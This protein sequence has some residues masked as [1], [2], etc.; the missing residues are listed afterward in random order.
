MPGTPADYDAV[1][2]RLL[3]LRTTATDKLRFPGIKL[4]LDGSIQG[5]TAV[6]KEPYYLKEGNGIW[7]IAP[8][9]IPR[10]VAAFHK[11][12]INVHAHCNGDAAVDAFIDAVDLALRETPWPDHRHTVQ[13]S[14]LTSAAQYRRMAKLGMC[15]NIFTNHIWYW[16]DQHYELTVGPERAMRMEA[17]ATARREGVRFSMHSDAS[18]TPLGQLHTMWCAVNRVTPKGRVLGEHE[19]I[20]AYDALHACTIDAAY[21][22]HLDDEVGSIEAGKRADFAVLEASPLDVDPMAIKDIPVWGTVLGG[23][24]HAAAAR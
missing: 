8:E 14:Q 5:Y 11:R 18:V 1:A 6:L 23:V 20:S 13:H 12:Y 21:Q 22:L 16:G 7:M 15:A 9:E 10:A 17:C 4:I 2:E 24:K 3:E 19:K